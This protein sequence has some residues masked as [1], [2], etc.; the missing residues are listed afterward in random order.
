MPFVVELNDITES[1]VDVIINSLGPIGREYGWLCRNILT[2]ADSAQLRSQVSKMNNPVGTITVTEA[3]E[4][5][6]KSIIHI[7]TPFKNDDEDCRKLYKAYKSVLDKTL[8]LGYKS[9]ALALNGTGYNGY[10][11]KESYNAAMEAVADILDKEYELDKNILDIRMISY[12]H[13]KRRIEKRAK[14]YIL[15]APRIVEREESTREKVVKESLDELEKRILAQ[16]K[17]WDKFTY[18][19]VKCANYMTEI[20]KDEL[21]QLKRTKFKAHYD[22]MS[23]YIYINKINVRVFSKAGLSKERRNQMETKQLTMK[24]ID[25]YRLAFITGM[26]KTEVIQWML[27][28]GYTFSPSSNLDLF[29]MD[30][31]DGKFGKVNNLFELEMLS[32]KYSVQETIQYVDKDDKKLEK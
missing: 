24:K 5:P 25:I 10:T 13:S 2:Y 15:G 31:F 7:V 8:E 22:F 21:L 32:E 11:E 26:S 16:N 4:L 28:V 9:I 6:C 29:F 30:Y 23:D 14:E 27:M 17:K 12:L 20:N 3:G 18:N 1:K 19:L